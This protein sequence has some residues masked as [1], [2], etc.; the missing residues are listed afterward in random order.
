MQEIIKEIDNCNWYY[1]VSNLWI[2][3]W[4]WKALKQTLNRKEKWYFRVCLMINWEKKYFYVH[5]LVAQYFCENQK[6][7]PE[8]NHI[9][10]NKLNN[11]HTNLEWCD[12]STNNKH[13]FSIWLNSVW[14]NH[15]VFWRYLFK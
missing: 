13:A 10:W 6:A 8:V 7:L 9:D 2:V 15:C 1:Q 3:Y 5:R 12:R 11:N 4:K 14:K